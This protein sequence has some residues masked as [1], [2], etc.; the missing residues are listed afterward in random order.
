MSERGSRV[1]ILH[2]SPQ[3]PEN[4]EVVE[5]TA[6]KLLAQFRLACRGVHLET[7][8]ADT[9]LPSE[10]D[11][12]KFRGLVI[13]GSTLSVNGDMPWLKDL[14]IDIR[15]AVDQQLPTFGICFGH[16][17]IAKACGGEVQAS[18]QGS[19]IGFYKAKKEMLGRGDPL[20]E[21]IG[22]CFPI[23]SWHGDVV[24]KQPE[25]SSLCTGRLATNDQNWNQATS[26]GSVG[27]TVQFHPEFSPNVFRRVSEITPPGTTHCYSDFSAELHKEVGNRILRNFIKN[28]VLVQK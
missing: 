4:Q 28:F 27:R 21:G 10:T 16:Q 2:I 3:P 19:R 14:F 22:D 6:N 20:F 26:I 7:V 5:L 24:T 11:L 25:V 9:G 8:R 23:T 12:E 15:A 18:K 13:S 17:A 1:D